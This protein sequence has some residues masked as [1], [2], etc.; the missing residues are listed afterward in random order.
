MIENARISST[1][2]GVHHTDHGILSFM[3]LVGNNSWGQGWGGYCL[4]DWGNEE[5]ERVPTETGSSLLLAVDEVFHV[6]WEDLK[7]LYCRVY[8]DD[9]SRNIRAI[10]NIIEDAWITY[11]GNSNLF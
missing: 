4:D 3:I 6:D 9:G 10:G 2:L 11:N 7:G 8:R 5:K 1:K